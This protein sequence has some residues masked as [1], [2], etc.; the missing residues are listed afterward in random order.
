M[1]ILITGGAGYVGSVL[2][3][4]LLA[5]GHSVIALDSLMLGQSGPFHLAGAAAFEFVRAD[6]RDERVLKGLLPAVDAIIPLAAIVG[7]PACDRD[8]HT[9]TTTNLDAIRLLNR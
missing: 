7:A 2:C 8:P 1:K 6:A 4:R 9:A 3:E 5:Q